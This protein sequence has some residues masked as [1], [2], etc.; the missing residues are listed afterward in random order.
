MKTAFLLLAL[1]SLTPLHAESWHR[2]NTSS[3]W[4]RFRSNSPQIKVR[5]NGVEGCDIYT[6]NNNGEVIYMEPSRE[7][8]NDTLV[9]RYSNIDYTKHGH[10]NRGFEFQ[11][12]RPLACEWLDIGVEDGF[13]VEFALPHQELPIVIYN[14][15][16]QSAESVAQRWEIELGL[17][18]HRAT[19]I[20]S[21]VK[22]V[23][24]KALIVCDISRKEMAR[25]SE[26][27]LGVPII[28]KGNKNTSQLESELR[29][30]LNCPMGDISTTIPISQRRAAGMEWSDHCQLILSELRTTTAK[31]A[32]IGNSIVQ[33][34]GGGSPDQRRRREDGRMS[35]DRYMQDYV[36][37]GIG[38][39]RV[40]NILYRVYND[41]LEIK[42]FEHILVM[43]G[44]NNIN[45][46]TSNQEILL[47]VENLLAQIKVR[48]PNA[49]I[50]LLGIL[51]RRDKPWDELQRLN[52][53][54]E[55]VA[56]KQGVEY[57]CVGRV[58]MDEDNTPIPEYYRDRVHLSAKGY[59]VLGEALMGK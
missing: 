49:R 17:R 45:A 16:P 34:W 24:A 8:S 5:H 46:K 58:L 50:T 19:E 20:I 36:N 52:I 22:R 1:L 27:Y 37:L 10:S 51:P 6:V 15:T 32:V 54:F 57:M 39:D 26:L 35:W 55:R 21:N 4:L 43:V 40:E 9:S 31:S 44:T 38:A 3:L 7:S 42:P 30:A 13:F 41:Q 59:L 33:N 29:K 12:L 2:H 18:M 47:G 14:P 25:L 23:P 11:L 56:N 53:E 48:Q 28:I